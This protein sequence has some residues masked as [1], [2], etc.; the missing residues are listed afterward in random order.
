MKRL[1]CIVLALLAGASSAGADS[2]VADTP[3]PDYRRSD[4]LKWTAAA[5]GGVHLAD[6]VLRNNHNGWPFSSHVTPATAAYL[7]VPS[8]FGAG[9]YFDGPRY[10]VIADSVLLVSVALTHSLLETPSHVYR[11]WTN[12]SNL[13]EAESKPTG[14]VA[15]AVVGVLTA[16][17]GAHLVSTIA[18][19]R[20]HGWTW[21][22]GDR[23]SHERSVRS[24]RSSRSVA[25]VPSAGGGMVTAGWRF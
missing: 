4:A 8:I 7:A 25:V 5:L 6:H 11:P 2:A 19:G 13:L 20:R 10:W 12:G 15:V 1:I 16:T 9:I 23:G 24:G 18:D 3:D 21:R 22:R 17:L 14:V